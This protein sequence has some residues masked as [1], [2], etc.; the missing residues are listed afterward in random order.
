MVNVPNVTACTVEV[1]FLF[2]DGTMTDL[3][4]QL[5][6][7]SSSQKKSELVLVNL[8]SIQLLHGIL[9]SASSTFSSSTN[10]CTSTSVTSSASNCMWSC[11]K[12]SSNFLLI[13][14]SKTTWLS[15]CGLLRPPLLHAPSSAPC[16]PSDPPFFIFSQALRLRTAAFSGLARTRTSSHISFRNLPPRSAV[17]GCPP[18]ENQ[19]L[20]V[21]KPMQPR[22]YPGRIWF[23]LLVCLGCAPP[24]GVLSSACRTPWGAMTSVLQSTASTLKALRRIMVLEAWS[25]GLQSQILVTSSLVPATVWM[26]FA[27]TWSGFR[28]LLMRVSS[29]SLPTTVHRLCLFAFV[30][31]TGARIL[32]ASRHAHTFSGPQRESN[33]RVSVLESRRGVQTPG[34][35]NL[36]V[37]LHLLLMKNPVSL[38]ML[39]RAPT[40]EL[41]THQFLSFVSLLVGTWHLIPRPSR[42]GDSQSDERDSLPCV[43][44]GW[45]GRTES[46]SRQIREKNECEPHGSSEGNSS[47][48]ELFVDAFCSAAVETALCSLRKAGIAFWTA[49][50]ALLGLVSTARAQNGCPFAGLGFSPLHSALSLLTACW[51]T[52][53]S[54]GTCGVLPASKFWRRCCVA[55]QA[56]VGSGRGHLS[57]EQTATEVCSG[58]RCAA[59]RRRQQ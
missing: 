31:A 40:I 54:T 57:A 38:R 8:L 3:R 21:A 10:L 11:P 27:H 13:P 45:P 37:A 48:A 22:V 50:S 19:L 24:P 36:E 12:T 28:W 41:N 7:P 49:G 44:L 51:R 6:A 9:Q 14:H 53:A 33:V 1:F 25:S 23:L 59:S 5:S 46:P 26:S 47:C 15:F 17:R 34:V 30:L 42:P 16:L 18:H 2:C 58:A 55:H 52:C 56:H 43:G 4:F 32:R 39:G 29:S 35:Q 20:A